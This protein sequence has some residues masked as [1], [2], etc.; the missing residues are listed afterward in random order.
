MCGRYTIRIDW[1][2]I[3]ELYGLTVPLEAEPEGVRARY[4]AAPGQALPIVGENGA[5]RSLLLSRWGL[6]P[7]WVA[8]LSEIR[9]STINARAETLETS[10]LYAEPFARRRCLVPADG[11]YEWAPPAPGEKK[12]PVDF[13]AREDGNP[14]AFAGLWGLWRD[15][16]GTIHVSHTIVTTEAVPAL[17]P[18]HP[19]MPVVLDPGDFD[20]WLRAETAPRHLLRPHGGPW[21]HHRVDN[22]V[23]KV[24]E[25]DAGLLLPIDATDKAVS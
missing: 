3:H 24:G 21:H 9:I 23:G 13:I 18:L 14:F 11:W 4:N 22:R 12:K 25:D 15:E 19:R 8:R 2:R 1:R 17:A 10:R 16:S 6:I 7:P 5:R 20:E